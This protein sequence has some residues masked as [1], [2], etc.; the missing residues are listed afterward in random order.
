MSDYGDECLHAVG[1]LSAILRC[2]LDD[3]HERV[4]RAVEVLDR[5]DDRYEEIMQ[6]LRDKEVR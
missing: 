1:K 5:L 3:D 4:R 6:P 2:P